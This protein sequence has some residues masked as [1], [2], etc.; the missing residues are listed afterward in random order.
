MKLPIISGIIDKITG[1]NDITAN[2]NVPET[3]QPPDFSQMNPFTGNE[4]FYKAAEL[5]IKVDS[6]EDVLNSIWQSHLS[7]RCKKAWI[8][9]VRSMYDRNVLLSD[10]SGKN[11]R[12]IAFI[13]SLIDKK[14][15][16]LA[17]SYPSDKNNPEFL[18]LDRHIMGQ[19]WYRLTRTGGSERERIIAAYMHVKYTQSNK[20][21]TG[22]E[23]I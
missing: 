23:K 12:E 11:D 14:A 20:L 13:R 21:T 6:Q 18:S 10:L 16:V 17:N 22:K 7:M 5:N 8:M 9:L 19:I 3:I 15:S 4:A 1:K 2:A